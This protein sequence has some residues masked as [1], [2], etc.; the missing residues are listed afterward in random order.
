MQPLSEL[1]RGCLD[2]ALA[3]IVSSGIATQQV[4]LHALSSRS[5]LIE[6]SG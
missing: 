4:L 1:A 2:R 6:Y 5:P 3:R